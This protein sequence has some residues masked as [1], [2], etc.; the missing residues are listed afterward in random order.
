MRQRPDQQMRG[1]APPPR[2]RWVGQLQPV[3][4]GFFT[5]WVIDDGHVTALG[6]VARLAVRAQL[7]GPQRPGQ[8]GVRTGVAELD[9]L[10]VQGAGPQVR[11]VGQ[12]L[13]GVGGER[14]EP[15]RAD[16]TTLSRGVNAHVI[17]QACAHVIPQV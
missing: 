9:Q 16:P 7:P 11:V 6:R 10:V 4:L 14:V 1:L 5:G 12:P 15:V 2:G 8:R 17:P 13:A 3:Q